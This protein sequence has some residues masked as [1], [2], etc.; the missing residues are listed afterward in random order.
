MQLFE[1]N[2]I[3]YKHRKEM[4]M[5]KFVLVA[6]TMLLGVAVTAADFRTVLTKRFF[7]KLQ[8]STVYEFQAYPEQLLNQLNDD[9]QKGLMNINADRFGSDVKY[10]LADEELYYA[11]VEFIK[12]KGVNANTLGEFRAAIKAA[13]KQFKKG[14]K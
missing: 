3:Y 13:G 7:D 4:K 10:E 2:Y 6:L 1:A 9:C 12:V 8:T 14:L 5:K 11:Y